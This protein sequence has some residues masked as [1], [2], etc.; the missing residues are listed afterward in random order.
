MIS[1]FPPVMELCNE[2][3]WP[4]DGALHWRIRLLVPDN[5]LPD[6]Y[7]TVQRFLQAND[8][9]HHVTLCKSWHVGVNRPMAERGTPG[10]LF[11]HFTFQVPAAMLD[12]AMAAFGYKS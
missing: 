2:N 5:R 8:D 7:A 11:C 10:P 4:N 3:E 6:C 1:D 9:A 12:D